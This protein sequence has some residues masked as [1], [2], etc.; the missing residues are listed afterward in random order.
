MNPP[1]IGE[2]FLTE[3]LGSEA[4][5]ALK[6]RDGFAGDLLAHFLLLALR[7]LRACGAV[8]AIVSDTM[9]T[10]DSSTELRRR[11]L[12]DACLRSLAWC[13]PFEGGVH[14]AI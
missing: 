1:Y 2:K 4:R 10:M 6:D 14:A 7:S 3:R 8:S 9:L 5:Q 13:R 11:L 12:G